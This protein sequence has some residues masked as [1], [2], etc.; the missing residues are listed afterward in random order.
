MVEQKRDSC[1]NIGIEFHIFS[2]VTYPHKESIHKEFMQSAKQTGWY[3]SQK[4]IST[5][6]AG[7]EYK[8]TT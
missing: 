3:A 5:G 8:Q 6:K 2:F 4:F 7:I 1:S